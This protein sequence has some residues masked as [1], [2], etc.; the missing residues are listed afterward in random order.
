LRKAGDIVSALFRE[1]FGPEFME[2]AR[3]NADLFSSWERVVSE[4]WPRSFDSDRDKDEVPAA[5]VHSRIRELELELL[6]IEADHPGWIQILQTKQT[7]L[8]SVVQ[9][10]YPELGIRGIAFRLSRE[11]FDIPL[12]RAEA[13]SDSIAP[14]KE[15]TEDKK[16]GPEV[17][18]ELL[19]EPP[20]VNR[21]GR[22]EMYAALKTLEESVKTRN[23]F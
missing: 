10:R 20:P 2:T 17:P 6:L 22:E 18:A 19:P 5:A 14:I 12:K 11:P 21:E 1:R 9:R 23:K 7:E 8:L 13:P 15:N 16:E 3:S 4:V